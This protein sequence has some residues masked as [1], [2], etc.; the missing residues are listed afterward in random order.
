MTE[1][2]L[3]KAELLDQVQELRKKVLLNMHRI[4]KARA[5]GCSNRMS[6][7]PRRVSRAI[8]C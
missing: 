8:T 3:T 1:L 2:L 4:P 6:W 5:C 7:R